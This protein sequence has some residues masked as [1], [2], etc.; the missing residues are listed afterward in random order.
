M[1]ILFWDIETR[2]CVNLETAGSWRYASDPTTEILCVGYA[3]DDDDPQ[4]WTPDSGAPIPEIF[5][6]AATDSAW[7]VVAHNYQFERAITTHV[8]TPRFNYP[9]IPLARQVCTMTMALAGALPGSLDTVAL[10]LG[11]AVQKDREG[12]QLMRKMSRPL[13]RRKKDPPDLIRW[14]DSPEARKRLGEYCKHDV[15]LERQV[16]RTLPPLS[17]AEQELFI[18]DAIVNQ[19]GFHVDVELAKAARAIARNER[20]AINA[21]IAELTEGKITSVDQVARI[22]EYV[23]QHGHQLASL[24]KRSVSAILAREPGEAVR[25]LLGL[26]REGARASVRKLDRLLVSAGTDNRLRGTL[27]FHA[28]STGRWSGRGYQP[29]NLKR[30]ETKDIDAAVDAILAGDMTRIQELGAPL[31]IAGDIQRSIICACAGHQLIAGDFSAIESRVL[32]WLANEQWKI[33]A[34]RKYDETGDPALEPYCVTATRMLGKTVTPEDEAGRQIGKTADLAL[35]FGG[36]IGAWRRFNP[37]DE[38]PDGEILLNVKTWRRAHPA[39]GALWKNLRRAA[40]QSVY[41]GQQTE[42]GKITFSMNNGT[43]LMTLPSGRTL[44]YPQAH[45]GPGKFENTREVHF[46]DN[47]QGGWEEVDSWHGLFTENAVQAISR[48]LLAAAMLR[49]EAAGYKVVLHVHDEV[50]CEVPEGSNTQSSAPLLTEDF[51]RRLLEPPDWAAGLPIAAKIRS[52][53][54]YAKSSSPRA[55]TPAA[56]PQPQA[57]VSEVAEIP[58][59]ANERTSKLP[60]GSDSDHNPE[61]DEEEETEVSLPDLIGEPL[62]DGKIL[63]PFHD[64]HTPSLRIYPDHY[65]CYA[66][67]CGAHG[68]AVDWLMKIEGMTRREANKYLATWDGPRIVPATDDDE[69]KA[70]RRRDCALKLWAESVPILGTTAARYLSEVR[71]IDLAVL[72]SSIDDALQFHSHCSFNGSRHPCLVALMR[73]PTTDVPTGIHRIA[74][75]PA[76]RKIDRQMLGHAGAVKLWPAGST[77]VVG[78]GLETVLAAATRIPYREAPLQPAWALLNAYTLEQFSVLPHVERLIILVD[79]DDAGKKAAAICTDRWQRAGRT[80]VCLT[81]TRAGADFNDLVMPEAVS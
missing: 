6:T 11:L 27:R 18:F 46:K 60:I 10:A 48:D 62:I 50:I 74:L 64:D 58:A 17:Q 69:E 15:E 68:T 7:H 66:G 78:E 42:C 21:Q 43:L 65:H 8:L 22:T 9:E 56:L 79:H 37:D 3:I 41:T 61:N 53:K 47:A 38:R 57:S 51:A 63:C 55:P 30:P 72:P 40:L 20:I 70:R 32:A 13:P 36:S 23:R 4:I 71:K 29:Q 5:V 73:H 34:Y 45:L 19:R 14:H 44:S 81:P 54:R 26:R 35:G 75:T 39:V 67:T 2:S 12:Y 33:E 49:L 52:G 1:P 77:L 28:A 59:E 76:G 80:V 24:G 16:Y 31:T 25:R